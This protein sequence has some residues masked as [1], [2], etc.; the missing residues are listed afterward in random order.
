MRVRHGIEGRLDP[1]THPGQLLQFYFSPSHVSPFL[2]LI[3]Q[4]PINFRWQSR[5][6]VRRREG[7]THL[8]ERVI[9]GKTSIIYQNRLILSFPH[10]EFM[11]VDSR[12]SKIL[13]H[14]DVHATKHLCH[15]EESTGTI[16]GRFGF[17]IPSLRLGHSETRW[18]RT[19]W[20]GICSLRDYSSYSCDR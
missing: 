13:L 11:V 16:E 14:R 1:V 19:G 8:F 9:D 2:M 10:V 17:L 5:N 12:W 20:C 3:S 6:N 18:R 7:D 15:E 4:V